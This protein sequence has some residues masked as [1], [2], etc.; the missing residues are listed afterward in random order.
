M[1]TKTIKKANNLLSD[2]TSRSRTLKIH[3]FSDG[4]F[5]SSLAEY[6]VAFTDSDLQSY[7]AANLQ[8]HKNSRKLLKTIMGLNCA[9]AAAKIAST[10]YADLV[11]KGDE[12][13]KS[14]LSMSPKEYERSF[15]DRLAR[16][17]PN[18]VR[19]E[20]LVALTDYLVTRR[21]TLC[22]IDRLRTALL[23]RI[24]AYESIL[25]SDSGLYYALYNTKRR[26]PLPKSDIPTYP[27]AYLLYAYT[28]IKKLYADQPQT[29]EDINK[30]ITLLIVKLHMR[31]NS[32]GYIAC[33]D[34]SAKNDSLSTDI[35]IYGVLEACDI[36][37]DNMTRDAEASYETLVED[38]QLKNDLLSLPF[39]H[40]ANGILGLLPISVTSKLYTSNDLTTALGA[41]ALASL[42]YRRKYGSKVDME[43]AD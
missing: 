24:N 39:T 1:Y 31:L 20:E 13:L 22:D 25:S 26:E 6:A 32:D 12:L 15:A 41:F 21:D 38:L 18:F 16:L 4:F 40:D 29:I 9:A 43:F 5:A 19:I 10:D 30:K 3:S 33:S 27:T 2:A 14:A 8:S 28:G 35:W 42:A 37:S 7:V 23:A 11:Y 36:I 34:K 17:K